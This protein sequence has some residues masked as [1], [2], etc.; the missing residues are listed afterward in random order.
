LPHAKIFSMIEA[1]L[2]T[3]GLRPLEIAQRIGY[4][5]VFITNNLQRYAAVHGY[6][7][8]FSRYVT[9]VVEADTNSLSGILVALEKLSARGLL[10]GVYT[11]CDYNLPLVAAAASG[12]GLPGLSPKAASAAQD[13]LACRQACADAGV[14]TPA[15]S[16][17]ATESDA[18]AAA[19]RI[20]FPCVVKPMTDSASTGVA[21]AFTQE[22]LTA[23][24]NSIAGQRLNARGQLRRPGA[25]VEEYALGYE[26]S[27]E[28]V[29]FQGETTVLGVTDKML[30]A[31]PYF[32]ETGHTFPSAL[33]ENVT[34][35]LAQTALDGLAAIGFDFGA[36]H[37]EIRMTSDGPKLI[38]INARIGGDEV[39]ALVELAFGFPY[40]EQVL[41]M[42]VGEEFTFAPATR[43]AAAARHLTAPTSGSVR[44]VHGTSLAERAPGVTAVDVKV[45]PGDWVI[46]AVSNHEVVG[47]VV[48]VAATAAEAGARA[49]AALA[50]IYL[51]VLPGSQHPEAQRQ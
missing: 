23:G 47:H 2:S 34:G 11:H 49:D 45:E 28:T 46:P 26:V 10:S 25:L 24:Y 16:Y 41:R 40:M 38:E 20:G 27:V 15:F 48:A 51:E 3:S 44:A 33:P 5:T 31:A 17:A 50:Q 8:T 21:L 4:D 14:S 35:A 42:H 29:T 12:L 36:A 37:T 43:K 9:D 19:Q 1:Q 22:Q 7:E 18:I 32:A 13:K 30:S 6:S 39:A